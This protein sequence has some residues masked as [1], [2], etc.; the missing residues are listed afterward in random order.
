MCASR[1]GAVTLTAPVRF[2]VAA[3]A[4]AAAAAVI[5]TPSA[6]VERVFSTGVYPVVQRTLTWLTNAVPI[7]MLDVWLV[8]AVV[9]VPTAVY[10][11]FRQ[12]RLE[13]SW[14]P[15]ITLVSALVLVIV[16][17]GLSP[18]AAALAVGVL[19]TLGGAVALHVGVDMVRHVRLHFP[20]T[21]D[22]VAEGLSWLKSLQR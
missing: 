22:A 14:Q 2:A 3:V 20:E 4:L 12:R 1:R 7:A 8:I 21:R 18:W 19:L 10:H 13:K 11:A 15:V 9:C 16:A 17:L 6:T 5:P